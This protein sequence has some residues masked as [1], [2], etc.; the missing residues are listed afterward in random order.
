MWEK[1]YPFCVCPNSKHWLLQGLALD[2]FSAL[3]TLAPDW[4][5]HP[6][7]WLQMLSIHSWIPGFDYQPEFYHQFQTLYYPGAF[8]IYPLR[9]LVH[10]SNLAC[11]KPNSCSFL[12]KLLLSYFFSQVTNSSFQLP[13]PKA[14]VLSL[15][16]FFVISHLMSN[17]STNPITSALKNIRIWQ[18]LTVFISTILIKPLLSF[19]WNVAKRTILVTCLL[20]LL[21][22]VNFRCL[23]FNLE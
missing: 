10:V 5:M 1:T 22:L 8:F 7:S 21:K 6:V 13:Q 12:P 9:C 17:L 20:Y 23:S 14:Q 4:R 15:S 2:V 3:S 16:P 11:V 19:T 18:F